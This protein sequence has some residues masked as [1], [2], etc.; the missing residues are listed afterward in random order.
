M[1]THPPDLARARTGMSADKLLAWTFAE[2]AITQFNGRPALVLGNNSIADLERITRQYI[3]AGFY[4]IAFP[5]DPI[6]ALHVAAGWSWNQAV[7][8]MGRLVV[9]VVDECAC[10]LP[11]QSCPVCVKAAAV[12]ADDLAPDGF[13]F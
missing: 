12:V 13:P 4:R 6:G 9:R 7:T 1:T 2:M 5:N 8:R 10:V 3:R 11:D